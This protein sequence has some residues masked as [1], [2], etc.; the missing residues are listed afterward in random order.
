MPSQN[1]NRV[2]FAFSVDKELRINSWNGELEKIYGKSLNEVQGIPYYEVI[3]R[4]NKGNK[5]AVI[6]ALKHGKPVIL[7]EYHAACLCGEVKGTI[8]VSPLKDTTG[9]ISGANV[10]ISAHPSCIVWKKLIQSQ[11][12]LDIGKI[13][14]TFAHGVRNPLNAIKGAVVYLREKYANEKKLIEFTKIIEEEILRL[15]N[16]IAKFLSTSISEK[17]LS[18]TDINVL[19]KKIEVLTS[20]QTQSRKIDTIFEYGN[21]Y[22]VTINSLHLE[23]AILNVL[24]NAIEAMPSGGRLMV[25]T[26]SEFRYGIEFATVEVS[27]TGPGIAVSRSAD[28][29]ASSK[30]K[31]KGL[32]LFITREILRSCGGHLEIKSQRGLGTTAKLYVPINKN[33]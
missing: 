18:E 19:L 24:N 15:D 12:L 8:R 9:K 13:A 29:I 6:E 27:D 3:P 2:R 31:G 20:L 25:K 1:S 11:R 10:V 28:M 14:A 16:F 22:P 5:D 33:G 32:G 30:V 4:I 7:N 23:H 21:T 17:G 26:Q